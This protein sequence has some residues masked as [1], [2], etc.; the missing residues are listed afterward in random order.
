MEAHV[1]EKGFERVWQMFQETDRKFQETEAEIKKTS[2]QI[3]D[4]DQKFDKYFGKLK[5]FD[6]NWGV[7]IEALVKPSVGEQFRKRDIPVIG[8]GQR[9]KRQIGGETMEIDILLT[10]GDA[11]IIVEVKTTLKVSDVKEHIEKRLIPFKRFFPEYRDK[12]VYGAVAY[13]HKEEDADRHAYQQGLFVLTF[14][15]GDLVTILND[16][17]FVPTCYSV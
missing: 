9:V 3:R 11:V 17:N 15:T 6:R 12:K 2:R 8:S 10:N 5:E 14:T 16:G 4:T 1:I 13:I 7:L